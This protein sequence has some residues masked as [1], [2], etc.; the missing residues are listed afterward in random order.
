MLC[1]VLKEISNLHCT[2]HLPHGEVGAK[3]DQLVE[4]S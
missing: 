3:S 1:C 2:L 4:D